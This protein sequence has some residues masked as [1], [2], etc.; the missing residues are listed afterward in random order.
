MITQCP[1]CETSF[2]LTADVLDVA[3]GR[4]R[5]GC[6]GNAFNALQQL[7]KDSSTK[8]SS[9]PGIADIEDESLSIL[10]Q[11][12]EKTVQDDHD[13]VPERVDLD[14]DGT[15]GDESDDDD[16]LNLLPEITKPR[17]P[18]LWR[19]SV[20]AL[21]LIMVFVLQ[22]A[23]F[24]RLRVQKQ[25]PALSPYYQRLCQELDCESQLQPQ[26][27]IDKIIMLSRDV[28]N[29]P[30]VENVL[31]VNG[32]LLNQ[33]VRVQDFPVVQFELYD[34]AGNLIG[35]RRFE[36]QEYLDSSIDIQRGMLPEQPVHI[37]LEIVSVGKKA[38]S[39]EFSFL[40]SL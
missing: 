1:E 24:Q 2:R 19:W 8:P 30:D 20:L 6:C 5:C 18:G 22:A 4:V 17:S 26:Q 33:S 16:E 28:R 14:E 37:V 7:Q 9:E 36:P 39:F 23:W 35:A 38:V 32:A 3:A 13:V 29:H 31:L 40:Q 12:P 21:L 27:Q 15:I 11:A 34:V 10:M 25:W